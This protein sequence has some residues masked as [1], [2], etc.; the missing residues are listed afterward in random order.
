MKKIKR[1]SIVIILITA[2]MLTTVKVYADTEQKKVFASVSSNEVTANSDVNITLNLS[3]IEY[4]SFTVELSSS[5]DISNTTVKDANT[6][7]EIE[8]KSNTTNNKSES[9]ETQSSDS[10]KITLSNIENLDSIILTIN[11][12]E[13]TETGSTIKINITAT[14]S[15]NDEN[16]ITNQIIL[17]VVEDDKE[18]EENKEDKTEQNTDKDSDKKENSE[19]MDMSEDSMKGQMQNSTKEMEEGENKSSGSSTVTISG[20]QGTSNSTTETVT[21]NGSSDNYLTN[22]YI[23]GT[24]ISDS[25]NKTNTT[26]FT[27]VDSDTDSVEISYDLSDSSSTVCIY[28]NTDLKSGVNK[29]LISVTAE[30]GDVRTYRIYVNK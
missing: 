7:K 11:I 12:P 19:D 17:N 23:D 16:S 8:K 25:F 30:N 5:I 18:D 6:G 21:Y 3:A 28:G 29:I 20:N 24:T 22:I 9:T 26:Y 4:E 2:I 13:D 1:M 27:S 15:E 14:D 10:K